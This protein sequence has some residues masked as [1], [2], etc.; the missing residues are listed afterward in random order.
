MRFPLWLRRSRAVIPNM[1][2]RFAAGNRSIVLRTVVLGIVA[3]F[4]RKCRLASKSPADRAIRFNDR[5]AAAAAPNGE[6]TQ[7]F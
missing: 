3:P 6:L 5:R 1:A 2:R 7:V 4:C